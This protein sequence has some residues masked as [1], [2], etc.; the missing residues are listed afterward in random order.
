[1]A[2][3]DPDLALLE[4]ASD[5]ELQPLVAY[6][7]DA[8]TNELKNSDLYKKF[9]PKHSMYPELIE[10]EI[11]KFG[12]NS[13]ANMFRDSGPAYKEIVCDTA[14]KLGASFKEE[15]PIAEIEAAIIAKVAEKAW[16]KMT[17]EEKGTFLKDIGI[18]RVDME[19]IK[20]EA[21]NYR[22]LLS[23]A[24]KYSIAPYSVSATIA[25]VVALNAMRVLPTSAIAYVVAPASAAL[26]GPIGWAV[27][28]AW[29]AF[30][31]PGPAFRVIIP[32]VLHIAFLR[33]KRIAEKP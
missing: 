19:A 18:D 24:G 32:C 30:D 5:E 8:K 15:W 26:L 13:F 25:G 11:R 28:G 20:K 31:V 6:I 21:F 9:Q 10:S 4:Q 23:R 3:F 22:E 27:G 16:E 17:D 33:Q 29:A 12:G 7:L 14:K 1:M 2:E